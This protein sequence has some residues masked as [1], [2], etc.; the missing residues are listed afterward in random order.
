MLRKLLPVKK[1]KKKKS[2]ILDQNPPSQ[3]QAAFEKALPGTQQ[4]DKT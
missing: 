3:N 4:A 2:H 1:G